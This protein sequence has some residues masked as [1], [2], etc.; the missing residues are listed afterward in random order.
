M[1]ELS[2][3]LL[4]GMTDWGMVGSLSTRDCHYVLRFIFSSLGFGG[5][6]SLCL[7]LSS[8]FA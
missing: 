2:V 4:C 1:L 8:C 3:L 7:G 6:I 5:V